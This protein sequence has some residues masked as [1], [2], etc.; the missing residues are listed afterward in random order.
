MAKAYYYGFIHKNDLENGTP[1]ALCVSYQMDY[2]GRNDR[3]L[4][5]PRSIC[6]IEEANNVGWH[7]IM[8]PCWFFSKNGKDYRR[9]MNITFGEPGRDVKV[10]I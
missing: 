7:K 2:T 3:D 9:I 5:I 4:W 8:I 1:K 6:I 10:I